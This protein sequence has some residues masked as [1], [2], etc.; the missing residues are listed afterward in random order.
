M[1]TGANQCEPVRDKTCDRDPEATEDRKGHKEG[2]TKVNRG[3]HGVTE[4]HEDHKEEL[5]EADFGQPGEGGLVLHVTL[6][7]V[8]NRET[9][10]SNRETGHLSLTL[11]T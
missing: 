6:Y 9:D 10:V 5:S 8:T 11:E 3:G 2:T 4:E 7:G 1:R